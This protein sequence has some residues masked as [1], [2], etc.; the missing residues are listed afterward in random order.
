[1]QHETDAAQTHRGHGLNI[2]IQLDIPKE[3][4][5]SILSSYY[6]STLPEEYN[7]AD[8][9]SVPEQDLHLAQQLLQSEDFDT[10]GVFRRPETRPPG[11]VYFETATGRQRLRRIESASTW[12]VRLTRCM[13]NYFRTFL[14]FPSA[15][16]S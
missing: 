1:M 6:M 7:P 4:V 16:H 13:V 15:T 10:S 3:R 14:Q 8:H 9:I 12:R 11:G 2:A 5:R